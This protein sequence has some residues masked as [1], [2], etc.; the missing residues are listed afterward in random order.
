MTIRNRIEHFFANGEDF[1]SMLTEAIRCTAE[2][3]GR[4]LDVLADLDR[5]WTGYGMRGRMSERQWSV[6][7][8]AAGY[9]SEPEDFR[10][11]D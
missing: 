1:D 5:S 9:D 6:L 7:W 4:V 8:H 11:D 2:D 10:P 3:K